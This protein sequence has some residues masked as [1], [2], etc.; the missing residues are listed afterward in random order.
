MAT[1][2]LFCAIHTV[3]NTENERKISG[4]DI[5]TITHTPFTLPIPIARVSLPSLRQP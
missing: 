5:P 2:S 3:N 1:L 4:V